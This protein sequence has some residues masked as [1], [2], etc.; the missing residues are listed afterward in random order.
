[1]LL[2]LQSIQILQ[3][4]LGTLST[5]IKLNEKS[6]IIKLLTL[7]FLCYVLMLPFV[8]S[9]NSNYWNFSITHP[10]KGWPSIHSY[11]C[12]ICCNNFWRYFMCICFTITVLTEGHG[13]KNLWQLLRGC[14]TVCPFF[15]LVPFGSELYP[16]PCLLCF[17]VV[18]PGF[19]RHE[20][21]LGYLV[22]QYDH[23][24]FCVHYAGT[25][26]YCSFHTGGS[27]YSMCYCT[28]RA[29]IEKTLCQLGSAL[30]TVHRTD[31]GW[32]TLTDMLCSCFA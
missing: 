21:Q 18:A 3:N 19:P 20:I 10:N 25:L 8:S 17:D 1:M 11:L 22:T 23:S 16:F 32:M 29:V 24:S 6:Q 26:W 2:L 15:D 14:A 30:A 4:N 31:N 27:V 7:G 5:D 28:C 13:G 9:K 12:Y